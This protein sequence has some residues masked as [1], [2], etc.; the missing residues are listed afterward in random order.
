MKYNETKLIL[1]LKTFSVNELEEFEKFIDSPYFKKGRDLLPFYK[2]LIKFHPDF[3]ENEF[4]EEKIYNELYPV[5]GFGDKSSKNMLKTLSS[6]LL[7]MAEEFLI[8]ENFRK[9][10][11]LKNRTLLEELLDRNLTKFYEQYSKTAFDELDEAG[12][13]SG[14][15]TLERYFLIWNNSRYYSILSDAKNYFE[16]SVSSGEIISSF[17]LV[18]ILRIAKLKQHFE[19]DLNLKTE[20]DVLDKILEWIDIEKIL[21]FYKGTPHYIFIGF[22]YYTYMCSI[23]GNDYNY[24]ILAKNIFLENRYQLSRT[25]MMNFYSDLINILNMSYSPLK[26]TTDKNEILNM[27]KYCLEDKAYKKSD[28]E[29]MPPVFYR[30]VILN[31]I[32]FKEYNYADDFVKKY[33]NDLD[34]K[35]REN[36]KYFTRAWISFARKDL[37]TALENISLVKY[38]LVNFKI[39]VK[40]LSLKIFYELDMTEQAYSMVDTFRHYLN[41]YKELTADLKTTYS[42]FIKYYLKTLK[43]RENKKFSDAFLIKKE[44]QNEKLISQGNWL[45]EKLNSFQK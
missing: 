38:D 1:F 4:F 11:L 10:Q 21:K 27:I 6:S 9:N 40:V 8:I 7:K 2:V 41:S 16:Q 32:H 30:N 31:S 29:Y 33:T 28:E 26:I 44:L 12:D 34:P 24:Y 19:Y 22:N 37:E 15:N 20:I 36:I 23:N 43:I 14:Q 5:T 13:L 17:Y 42:N 39:D 45:I 3:N 18:N 35:F 25:E